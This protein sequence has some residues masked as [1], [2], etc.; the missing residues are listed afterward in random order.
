MRSKAS[1]PHML[2]KHCHPERTREGSGH[3]S[4][5]RSFASTL[6]MTALLL[7]CGIGGCQAMKPGKPLTPE[8][9]GNDPGQQLEFWHSLTTEPVTTNDEAF[10][11]LLLYVDG[12]DDSADY[13][14]R[15]NTLK[16]RKMLP[17]GF[18]GAATDA[19]R[20]GTLAVALMRVLHERGGITTTLL[21]RT[22]R[23]ATRELN[24]MNVYPSS[25]PNQTFSG[26]EYVGIIGRVE[27]FQRGNPENVSAQV[28][29]GEMSG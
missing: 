25:T 21:G 12:K 3:Y 15:V 27:D 16:A 17:N 8:L 19:V 2:K 7:F 24:F 10:H 9:A 4:G 6:R 5:V 23:Y 20:R 13:A 18:D 11:G 28:T 29:P 14:A 26:N 1:A 22:P